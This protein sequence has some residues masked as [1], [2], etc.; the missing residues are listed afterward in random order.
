[1]WRK[2]LRLTHPDAGGDHDLFVWA[3]EL[4][5]RVR[6]GGELP[7]PRSR[8]ATREKQPPARV[9]FEEAFY[10]AES[11]TDLTAQAVALAD[12]VDPLYGRLLRLLEDCEEAAEDYQQNIGSTYKQLAYA[13]HLAGMDAP[14]R[15]GW[16][17][18]AC[19]VP[20]ASKHAG[21]LISKLK[22]AKHE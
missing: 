6:A 11:F 21:H 9:P 20:L 14:Q 4:Q 16:Y 7:P 12:K 2:L 22:E 10:K 8:K 5:E 3:R 1:M 19:S 18:V 15:N 17:S 13:A